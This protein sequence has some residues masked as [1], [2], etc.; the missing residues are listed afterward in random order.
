VPG[1]VTVLGEWEDKCAAVLKEVEGRMKS[2]REGA[3]ERG[4]TDEEWQSMLDERIGVPKGG[5][6][7]GKDDEGKGGKRDRNDDI[8]GDPKRGGKFG[9]AGR[10]VGQVLAG[11]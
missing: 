11:N 5:G 2:V 8:G 6:K 4:R 1:L 10:R 7:A 9:G 3:K